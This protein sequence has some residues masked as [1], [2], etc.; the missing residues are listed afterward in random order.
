M[1]AA[2]LFA[3]GFGPGMPL[4]L[5][6]FE[7]TARLFPSTVGVDAAGTGVALDSEAAS[8][9]EGSGAGS[10]A[11]PDDELEE[12]ARDDLPSKDCGGGA[13]CARSF[14]FRCSLMILL[15]LEPLVETLVDAGDEF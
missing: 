6:P 11:S 14:L 12:A 2:P 3:P 4:F 5:A 13:N 1:A 15:F 8:V 9:A 7:G 10:A